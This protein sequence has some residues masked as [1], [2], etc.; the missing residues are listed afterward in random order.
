MYAC[1]KDLLPKIQACSTLRFEA[2]SLGLQSTLQNQQEQTPDLL[3]A[4]LKCC[5]LGV[6][7]S[8][9][10]CRQD[11]A[12]NETSSR[13]NHV[14]SE[15]SLFVLCHTPSLVSYTVSTR[16]LG[17]T[18]YNAAQCAH[19]GAHP[20]GRPLLPPC[21]NNTATVALANSK[22]SSPSL[23][24]PHRN[25]HLYTLRP[26]RRSLDSCASLHAVRPLP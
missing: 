22:R 7:L 20:S 5:A 8:A 25:N 19:L 13:L 18:F 12:G 14:C 2:P 21:W 11:E 26:A 23:L 9:H 4:S 17:A 6:R 15:I 16:Q 24:T 1:M 10:A 3:A